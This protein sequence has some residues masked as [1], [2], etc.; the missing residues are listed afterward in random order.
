MRH[1]I[2]KIC[3]GIDKIAFYL[4]TVSCIAVFVMMLLMTADVVMR[5]IFRS[6]IRG[7][8]ELAETMMVITVACAYAWSQVR[9]KHVRVDMI[10][11]KFPP[12]ALCIVD[13]ISFL[14]FAAV[15]GYCAFYQYLA[16]FAIKEVGTCTTQLMIKQW[17]MYLLIAIGLTVFFLVIVADALKQI[18]VISDTFSGKGSAAVQSA[19]EKAEAAIAEN[20]VED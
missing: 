9:K 13:L 3:S 12:R 19:M 15:I 16:A 18:F 1:T 10:I 5:Y 6:P 4:S 11:G 14:V 8:Y 2:E 20:D 7:G 17:W